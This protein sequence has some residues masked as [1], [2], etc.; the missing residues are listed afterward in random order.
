MLEKVE[1][2][3]ENTVKIT[4]FMLKRTE[5]P[6]KRMNFP[7]KMMNFPLKMMG[8][9][10]E[11]RG[12]RDIARE[13]LAVRGADRRMHGATFE[14]DFSMFSFVGIGFSLGFSLVFY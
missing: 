9:D 7:L 2:A 12:R 5:F 11:R 3:L 4:D 6:P 14:I 1:E 10:R 13:K 8:L